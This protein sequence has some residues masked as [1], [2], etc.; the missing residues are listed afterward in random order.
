M[1]KLFVASLILWQ[2]LASVADAGAW[3]REKGDGFVS[4]SFGATQFSETTNAFY[5]EYGLSDK[6]TIGLDVSAFTNALNVR[7]GFGNL[8]LRRAIGPADQPDKWAYELGIG[9][10]WGN[11][12]HRPTVKAG[13]AWG[14]GF[15]VNSRAGW[16]NLDA[17]YIHEPTLGEHITKFDAAVGMAFSD[18]TTG[19]LEISVSAQKSE[20]YG[21][22]EPSLLIQPKDSKFRIKLGAQIPF[23]EQEKTALKM[24]IWNDF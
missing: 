10:V 12:M 8:F 15:K 3:L 16:I 24:G 17:A 14:R 6:T 20:T 11:E 13:I 19:L 4:L 9:G 21:A 18:A 22:F 2:G 1:R 23:S 7:N 5:I